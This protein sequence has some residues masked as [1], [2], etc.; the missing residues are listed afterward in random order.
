MGLEFP[1]NIWTSLR[2]NWIGLSID[3]GVEEIN[4]QLGRGSGNHAALTR[5]NV[6]LIKERGIKLKINTVVTAL[7]WNEDMNW[8]MEELGA[9]RWKVFQMLPIEGENDDA[10][11]LLIEKEKFEHF[12]LTHHINNPIFENNELMTGSYVM[13]DPE[14][15]LFHNNGGIMNHLGDNVLNDFDKQFYEYEF[16]ILKF[17]ER[18][19]IYRW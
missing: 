11:D 3:S 16:D 8:V 12:I 14:G 10:W 6:Q 15:R 2:G 4:K 5:K 9:E 17:N 18:G 1:K 19:G 13:I 7:N